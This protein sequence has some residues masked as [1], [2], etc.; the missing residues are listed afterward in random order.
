MKNILILFVI[1]SGWALAQSNFTDSTSVLVLSFSEPMNLKNSYGPSGIRNVSNYSVFEISTLNAVKIYRSM[2]VTKI[3]DTVIDTTKQTPVGLV[4]ERLNYQTMYRVR[5]INITDTAGN[6]IDPAHNSWDFEFTGN[7]AS[8]LKPT[9]L[10]EDPYEVPKN[11]ITATASGSEVLHTPDKTIDGK[12][13]YDGDVD[14][15]WASQPIPQWI[16]WTFTSPLSIYKTVFSLNYWNEN[17]LWTYNIQGLTSSGWVSLVPTTQNIV[18]NEWE[19]KSFPA[20]SVSKIR[21]NFTGNNQSTW[22]GLW[23][24]KFYYGK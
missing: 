22:A 24:I 11:F 23:E 21:M 10:L 14:S 13:F 18:G 4:L 5:V 3:G 6:I 1:I 17:R 12:S 7:T 9:V 8:I 16:E 2:L 19:I 20:Q 15:R